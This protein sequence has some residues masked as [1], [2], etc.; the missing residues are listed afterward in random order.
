MEFL[1]VLILLG[2][3]SASICLWYIIFPW[4]IIF[5]C[6]V[7]F[8]WIIFFFCEN[9]QGS[10]VFA[11]LDLLGYHQHLT[12]PNVYVNLLLWGFLPEGKRELK[13]QTFTFKSMNRDK[14]SLLNTCD[15]WKISNFSLPFM[16]GWPAEGFACWYLKTFLFLGHLYVKN[17]SVIFDSVFAIL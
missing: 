5:G 11:L 2:F 17:T 15:T 12:C 13:I 4:F 1:G 6:E 9:L 3:V 14:T 16:R 10:F 7:I 8:S